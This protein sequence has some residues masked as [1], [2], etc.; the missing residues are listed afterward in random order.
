MPQIRG[1]IGWAQFIY[2]LEAGKS[3]VPSSDIF[4]LFI[5]ISWMQRFS[6]SSPYSGIMSLSDRE[7]T[8]LEGGHS[9]MSVLG[10]LLK[11]SAP[12]SFVSYKSFFKVTCDS[13]VPLVM[14]TFRRRLRQHNEMFCFYPL[15][16]G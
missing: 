15:D 3:N 10:C 6:L 16:G 9:M 11:T 4:Y 7:E 12:T 2:F 5:F 1:W 8:G 14:K 13:S